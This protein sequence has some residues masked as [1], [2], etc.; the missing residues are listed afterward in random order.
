M[1][2]KGAQTSLCHLIEHSDFINYYC[3]YFHRKITKGNQND[4]HSSGNFYKEN[5]KKES[6]NKVYYER[7]C[8]N[9]YAIV[10]CKDDWKVKGRGKGKRGREYQSNL[11]EL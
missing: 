9:T 2:T 1:D 11:S 10:I 8:M 6:R 3:K 5:L 4:N 7:W